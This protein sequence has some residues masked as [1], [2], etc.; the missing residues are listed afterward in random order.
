VGTTLGI[1]KI[2]G[3]IKRFPK[4]AVTTRRQFAS[5]LSALFKRNTYRPSR[6]TLVFPV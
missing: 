6:P 4:P 5:T 1:K 3:L 2:E